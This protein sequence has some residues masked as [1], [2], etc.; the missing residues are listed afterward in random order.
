MIIVT[1]ADYMPGEYGDDAWQKQK[2]VTDMVGKFIT[3]LHGQSS[4]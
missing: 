1:P 4:N 2:S 3:G